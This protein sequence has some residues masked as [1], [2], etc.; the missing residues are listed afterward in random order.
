MRDTLIFNL[1]ILK[2]FSFVEFKIESVVKNVEI[3]FTKLSSME[4]VFE[5]AEENGYG[6]VLSEL[7]KRVDVS[8][9]GLMETVEMKNEQIRGK[10]SINQDISPKQD[11][12]SSKNGK[13]ERYHA[14]IF[15]T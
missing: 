13:R 3:L 5:S 15:F 4:K 8:Y 2:I 7:N 10:D 14:I 9:L 6:N 12:N 1:F 11:E